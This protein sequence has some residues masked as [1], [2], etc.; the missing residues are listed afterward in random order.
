MN[1]TPQHVRLITGIKD[2]F[3]IQKSMQFSHQH[4]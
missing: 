4:I 1:Y 2:W 3:D